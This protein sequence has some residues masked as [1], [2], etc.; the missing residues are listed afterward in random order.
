M[1]VDQ[2]IL[3]LHTSFSEKES[4]E[5]G[6]NKKDKKYPVNSHIEAS[7]LVFLYGTQKCSFF[8]K[9]CVRT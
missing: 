3:C 4:I 6:L 9:T 5:C 7:K 2:D 1:H 8:S